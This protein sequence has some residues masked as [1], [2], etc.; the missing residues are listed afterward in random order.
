MERC[1]L[2]V[3]IFPTFGGKSALHPRRRLSALFLEIRTTLCLSGRCD[4]EAR[5]PTQSTTFIANVPFSTSYVDN[6]VIGWYGSAVRQNSTK[7]SA[8]NDRRDVDD[9]VVEV[10]SRRRD[11]QRRKRYSLSNDDITHRRLTAT[12][13][14]FVDENGTVLTQQRG[15]ARNHG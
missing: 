13:G 10:G 11:N 2:G 7:P 15:Q 4:D 1:L 3:S 9:V 12:L 5:A 6:P 14:R 8:D